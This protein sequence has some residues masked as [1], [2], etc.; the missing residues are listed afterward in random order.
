MKSFTTQTILAALAYSTV[1]GLGVQRLMTTIHKDV[2][3]VGETCEG[4]DEMTG[5]AF[6]SCAKG[7]VC[8][9]SGL[10]T[11]PGASK[12]CLIDRFTHK[13]LASEGETCGGHNEE[14]GRPFAD[15]AKGLVCQDLGG[16]GIPGTNN[17]C[18]REL[19]GKG[20]TCE[21]FN[22][23]TG[24]AFPS[25]DFGLVCVNKGGVTIP[26]AGKHCIMDRPQPK[27]SEG[28]TCGG[29]NEETERP[30]P[31]CGRGLVCRPS[32]GIS[33]PG[34]ENICMK[35]EY[36]QRSWGFTFAQTSQKSK[37][38]AYLDETCEGFNPV[39]GKAFP[40]CERGLKCVDTGLVSIGGGA[41]KVCKL[42]K[43]AGPGEN[44]EGHNEVTGQAF[45]RCDD[46]LVCVNHGGMSLPGREKVCIS[47]SLSIRP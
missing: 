31:N 42:D 38:V 47:K 40:S 16:F 36:A 22:Q 24:V 33:L 30:Y 27:A 46:G 10:V 21:G 29:F 8:V 6:P 39:T 18:V 7:L 25:C 26:G 45:P 44:C 4:Y 37:D 2:A 3:G 1:N 34:A 15:C 5:M 19:A 14:T 32:G 11:I 17:V 9:E 23:M 35:E 20:E 43:V 12:Y 13:P 41:S 28:E